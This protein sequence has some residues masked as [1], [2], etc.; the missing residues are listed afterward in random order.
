MVLYL[1]GNEIYRDNMAAGTPTYLSYSATVA[2]DDGTALL[3]ATLPANLVGIP[4]LSLPIGVAD[5]DQMPVGLQFLAPQQADDRLYNAAAG[6]E[7]LLVD[8]WGAPLID[9]APEVRA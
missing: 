1:N 6:L 5:E 8:S 3:T 4:G 9:R 7:R 2:G